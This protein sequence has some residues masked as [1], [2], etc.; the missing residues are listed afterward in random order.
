MD[1]DEN[2]SLSDKLKQNLGKGH[3][4]KNLSKD[5]QKDLEENPRYKAYF[6]QHN[7]SSI[8]FFIERYAQI[9]NDYIQFSERYRADAESKALAYRPQAEECLW[10]IQLKKLFDLQCQWRAE[11]VVLE[12]VTSTIDFR[13]WKKNIKTCPFLDPITSEEVDLYVQFLDGRTTKRKAW[14]MEWKYFE[15]IK[16]DLLQ[17]KGPAWFRFHNDLTG[18]HSLLH[19]PDIRGDKEEHYRNVYFNHQKQQQIADGTYKEYEMD[20]K[21]DLDVSN[22]AQVKAFVKQFESQVDYERY[23]NYA[24]AKNADDLTDMVNHYIQFM[25][26]IKEPIPIAAHSDWRVGV[27]KALEAYENRKIAQ[28][29]HHVFEDYQFKLEM[30]IGYEMVEDKSIEHL[31]DMVKTQILTG[32]ELSGE[33]RDFNF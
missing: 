21:P 2:Q 17:E 12:G 4:G 33:P 20:E 6:E 24:N 25:H 19:L 9:K 32:R 31:I 27:I 16:E 30:G 7:S 14:G 10:D 22:P 13:W 11:Q 3:Q 15:E 8:K 1:E 23:L 18:R 29:L 26:T 28:V 5:I